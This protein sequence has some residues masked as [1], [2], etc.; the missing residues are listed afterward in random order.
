MRGGPRQRLRTAIGTAIPSVLRR[1]ARLCAVVAALLLAFASAPVAAQT[2]S[3]TST[4]ANGT[5]YVVGESITTRISGLSAGVDSRTGTTSMC[6]AR[7]P[8]GEGP[9]QLGRQGGGGFPCVWM[10]IEVGANT[11][12]AWT[13]TTGWT[14]G[15]GPTTVD[16]EYIVVADDVDTDGISIPQNS[17]VGITW[18]QAINFNTI[19]RNHAAL[20]AN[21]LHKVTGSAASISS[22]MPAALDELNLN[23]ATVT[24]ALTGVTFGSAVTTSSFELETT[25]TG[26]TISTVSSVSSGDTEA[27]LTLASTA[28]L[29]ANAS[30]AVKVLAAAH[31]GGLDLTTQTV[32]VTANTT[33][34]L[35]T[36][37]NKTLTRGRPIAQFQI[38]VAANGNAPITYAATGLRGGLVFDA[39]GSGT[40]GTPRAIC[41]TPTTATTYTVTITVSDAQNDQ[42][43]GTFSISVVAPTAASPTVLLDADQATDALD[44]GPV[45]LREDGGAGA[46]GRYTARLSARPSGNVTV[47]VASGDAAA[48]AVDSDSSLD[49]DS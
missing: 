13:I 22:T 34:S 39:D 25:M 49:R 42:D 15:S 43:T 37:E 33:P 36:L 26:V 27:T 8:N 3:I 12:E 7:R 10:Q 2:V 21:P 18:R 40:C 32:L 9:G 11:R 31:S 24:V 41:G 38:P 19:S 4:P 47:A 20:A 28:S 35:G 44:P 5:H 29:T 14:S 17:I 45:T 30:L 23:G 16:F 46:A 1:T 6:R 48:V